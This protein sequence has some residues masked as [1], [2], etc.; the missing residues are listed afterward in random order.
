MEAGR[1]ERRAL[2]RQFVVIAI[3]FQVSMVVLFEEQLASRSKLDDKHT[4]ARWMTVAPAA[5]TTTSCDK[6]RW[7]KPNWLGFSLD[8]IMIS[9][10]VLAGLVSISPL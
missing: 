3:Q 7:R 4:T 2:D 8:L 5:P 9:I 6:V 10:S 1:M